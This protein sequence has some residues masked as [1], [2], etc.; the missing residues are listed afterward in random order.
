MVTDTA[1]LR[2]PFYH[3][4]EDTPEKLRYDFL[5][6][7]KNKRHFP[8]PAGGHPSPAAAARNAGNAA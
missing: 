7:R 1:P 3:T 5:T 2:Y 4:P 8:T 6:D